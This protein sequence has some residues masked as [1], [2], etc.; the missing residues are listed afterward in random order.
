MRI[1]EHTLDR[2]NLMHWKKSRTWVA[3]IF[4]IVS[5]H[6]IRIVPMEDGTSDVCLSGKGNDVLDS[7]LN[8]HH[9]QEWCARRSEAR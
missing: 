1:P 4:S 6:H 9:A 2:S 3:T 7:K 8:R 5:T